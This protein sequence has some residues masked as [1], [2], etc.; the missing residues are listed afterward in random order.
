MEDYTITN[1]LEVECD[2]DGYLNVKFRLEGED[3]TTYREIETDEY[4]YWA[5]EN[6]I[7]NDFIYDSP[8]SDEEEEIYTDIVFNFNRWKEYEHDEETVTRF[9]EDTYRTRDEL[10]DIINDKN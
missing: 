10:P 7:D 2:E 1:I 4:F 6:F 3:V 8:I 9:I 5:E